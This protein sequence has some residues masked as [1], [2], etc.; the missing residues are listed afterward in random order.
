MHSKDLP[1]RYPHY[2]TCTAQ[3]S[4][5]VGWLFAKLPRPLGMLLLFYL[6]EL[7]GRQTALHCASAKSPMRDIAPHSPCSSSGKASP[8]PL[9]KSQSSHITS[10]LGTSPRASPHRLGGRLSI[11]SVHPQIAVLGRS[12]PQRIAVVHPKIYHSP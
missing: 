5:R 10:M 1:M 2:H 12:A 6:Q 3:P 4:F 8:K 7:P 9:V 11:F